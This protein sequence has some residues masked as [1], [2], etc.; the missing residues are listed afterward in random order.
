MIFLFCMCMREIFVKKIKSEIEG[1]CSFWNRIK[2]WFKTETI[3]YFYAITNKT[4]ISDWFLEA[5]NRLILH[6]ADRGICTS[7][8]L[9]NLRN[10]L[11]SL[12]TLERSGNGMIV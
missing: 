8:P 1:I 9:P 4:N 10:E 12:E 3:L 6:V 5:Q 7:R 2:H 11:W